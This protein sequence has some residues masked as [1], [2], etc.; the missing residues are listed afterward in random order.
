MIR[1]GDYISK[2]K[3]RL[4]KWSQILE[5]GV[6]EFISLEKCQILIQIDVKVVSISS[7]IPYRDKWKYK[8][9]NYIIYSIK[10]ED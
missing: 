8:K 6:M 1:L 4:R 10:Y 3:L 7:V 5:I 2:Q 9:Y